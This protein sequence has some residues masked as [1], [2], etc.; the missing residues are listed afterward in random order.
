MY[1]V[2]LTL[3]CPGN[4]SH[5]VYVLTDGHVIIQLYLYNVKL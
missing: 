2:F 4:Q 1:A 5:K 3:I